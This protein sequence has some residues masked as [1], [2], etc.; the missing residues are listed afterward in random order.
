MVSDLVRTH[1]QIIRKKLHRKAEVLTFQGTLCTMGALVL[2]RIFF[3]LFRDI[4]L[5]EVILEMMKKL[6]MLYPEK[7]D[8]ETV[9]EGW[10][11][12]KAIPGKQGG[13]QQ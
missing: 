9:E 8:G 10:V 1:T 12:R 3:W 5:H 4:F 2:N 6:V 11:K 7:E 13:K